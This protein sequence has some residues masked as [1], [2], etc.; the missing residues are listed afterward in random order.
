MKIRGAQTVGLDAR[1]LCGKGRDPQQRQGVTHASSLQR[2][3]SPYC[4]IPPPAT[5]PGFRPRP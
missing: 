2:A 1:G 4:Q 5:S 3:R